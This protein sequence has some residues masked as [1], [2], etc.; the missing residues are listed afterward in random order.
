MMSREKDRKRSNRN[1]KPRTGEVSTTGR[2]SSGPKAEVSHPATGAAD[3]A[4][5]A[6]MSDQKFAEKTGRTWKQW[7]RL[8]D[9]DRAW[10]M[11]H[12]E[13]AALVHEKHGVGAWWA[14]T[15]T[16]GYE[17]L[18][19]LR[20][21]G[22]RRGGAFEAVKSKTFSV[23]VDVLFD[24]WADDTTRRRW[25]DGAKIIVRTATAS[26]SMRLQW[27][28]GTIVAVWFSSKG[29]AKSIAAVQHTNL[30]DRKASDSAKKY[31]AER[32]PWGAKPD[33]PSTMI[34]KWVEE[35]NVAPR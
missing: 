35:L 10:E 20:E 13:I 4:A 12:R 24:A 6:G 29:D 15:V 34:P 25:L 31:W 5:V 30:S 19:G 26:K 27:P 21:R 16:V 23:P 22:Q 11:P 28:D 8:L 7:M 3:Q 18:K 17:R 33:R 32:Q 1:W 2:A 14:Q 9:A